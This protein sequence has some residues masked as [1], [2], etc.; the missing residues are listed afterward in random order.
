MKSFL[1]AIILLLSTNLILSNN[2]KNQFANKVTASNTLISIYQKYISPINQS[3]CQSYPSC[4]RYSM[5]AIERHGLWGF[6]MTAD[7]LN[8]CGHDM[9][10]YE[11]IIIGNTIKNYDPVQ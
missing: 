6:L 5:Q 2:N 8:R 10:L 7:R 1:L 4:S 11:K 9:H 3:T